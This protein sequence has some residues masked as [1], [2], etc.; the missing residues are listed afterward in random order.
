MKST[1]SALFYLLIQTRKGVSDWKTLILKRLNTVQRGVIMGG[2][3][4]ESG[5]HFSIP[6]GGGHYSPYAVSEQLPKTSKEAIGKKGKA[7]TIT[8]ALKSVNPNYS[9]RYS[10][11]S[12]NCQR[13]VVAY[14]LQRRGYKVEAQPTF[15]GDTWGMKRNIS[16][17]Y[18]DRWRGAF[19]H[20]KTERVGASRGDNVLDNIARK[21][22]E[23]GPG[24]RAVVSI[25]YKGS[26]VGHVFNVEN[27][28][29]RIRY[30]DA[31]N[32]HQ[33]NRASMRNL[34]AITKTRETTLTRTDNLRISERSKEFVW[35]KDRNRR[36]R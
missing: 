19:R 14:E 3:G 30:V 36:R 22:K 29:G 15:K 18:M 25:N 31:Q 6:S 23:Y 13:C 11:Y 9:A 32:G 8:E 17:T 24:A 1:Y 34:F 10:E 33:Y 5:M 16:G 28:R 27:V 2:R 4:A 7:S 12:Q 21:M 26:R 20:A 35:T